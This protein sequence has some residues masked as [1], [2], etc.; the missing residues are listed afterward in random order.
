MP[1]YYTILHSAKLQCMCQGLVATV[2]IERAVP[3][4]LE[5]V[6]VLS[7]TLQITKRDCKTHLVCM[8]NRDVGPSTLVWLYV[9]YICTAGQLHAR[10][11]AAVAGSQPADAMR[12]PYAHRQKNEMLKSV[13]SKLNVS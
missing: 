12:V 8:C 13:C 11:A 10:A 5:P 4:R 1:K 2:A 6:S 9:A 3:I 7:Y